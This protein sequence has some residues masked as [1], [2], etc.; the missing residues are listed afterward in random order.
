MLVFKPT[1]GSQE[2]D[3]LV[4]SDQETGSDKLN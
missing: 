1:N 2:K 3:S 4:S